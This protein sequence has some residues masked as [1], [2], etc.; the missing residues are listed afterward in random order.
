MPSPMRLRRKLPIRKRLPDKRNQFFIIGTDQP[1]IIEHLV[2]ETRCIRTPR[3]AEEVDFRSWFPSAREK[4]VSADDMFVEGGCEG[5]VEGFLG[6]EFRGWAEGKVCEA[7]GGDFGAD[8]GF[9]CVSI[10]TEDR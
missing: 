3:E 2:Q 10:L 5:E 1:D 8:A 6:V 9:S 7:A 4:P